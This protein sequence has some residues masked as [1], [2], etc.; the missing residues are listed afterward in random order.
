MNQKKKDYPIR[1][2]HIVGKVI[3]GGVDAVVM[4]YYR[5]IDKSKV[6]F[7]LLMDGNNKTPVD[8][9]I[10]SMGGRVFK[11]EPYE[12]SM[13]KNMRQCY[14]ILKDNR[15]TIVHCHLNTLSVFPLCAAWFAGVKIRIAHNHSTAAKGEGK[16]TLMKHLLRPFAKLFATHYCA[17]SRYA[18]EWLFGKS[19]YASGKVKLIQNAIDI[20]R[21]SYNAEMRSKMR[22]E[23][24]INR[25]YVVGH[26]GRFMYQ[27]NHDFLIDIFSKIWEKEAGALLLLV[28]TGELEPAIREKVKALGL[29][30][31]VRFMGVRHDVPNL[32]QAMDVFVLPSFYEGLPVVGVEAQAAGLPC[33]LSDAMTRETKLTEIAEFVSLSQPAAYWA[34]RAIMRCN[35]FERRKTDDEL[36]QAGFEIVTAADGLREW[37]EGLDKCSR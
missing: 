19:T 4:N 7:D 26:V 15:Y 14:R 1:V 20:S 32:L 17:C 5:N 11:L 35:G 28:G 34:E 13:L 24:N 33:I 3:T 30:D 25:K 10:K 23:L 12:R 6:Q 2:A 27:K 8:E 16:R 36:K 29:S 9:E 18:G 37:Y 22:E 31:A 21:Y